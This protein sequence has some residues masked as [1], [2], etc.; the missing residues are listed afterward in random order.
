MQYKIIEK[1]KKE[2][3]NE[4]RF[5]S[6]PQSVDVL[7]ENNVKIAVFCGACVFLS[8]LLF[9]K[10]FLIAAFLFLLCAICAFFY[11]IHLLKEKTVL[12]AKKIDA[13]LPFALLNISEQLN[14][15]VPFDFCIKRIFTGYAVLSRK[16]E[17]KITKDEKA[18]ISIKRS[19]LELSLATKSK[20]FTRALSYIVSVYDTSSGKKSGESLK[21]LALELLQRQKTEIKEFSE[22][23]KMVSLMLVVFAALIPSLF[24]SIVLVGSNFM[25]LAIS[26]AM[27]FAALIFIFPL[28]DI[29]ILAYIYAIMPQS[30]KSNSV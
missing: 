12:E 29:G 2:I 5:S 30:L 28:I 1:I 16:L 17:E 10:D 9:A 8:Y 15:G 6:R 20:N 25:D 3:A 7:F 11:Q 4:M 13:S 21:K 23:T 14:I 24:S 18:G 27:L 22:K 19:L 26:G